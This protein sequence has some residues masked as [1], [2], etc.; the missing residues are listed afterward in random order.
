MNQLD[1][2]KALLAVA[3]IGIWGYGL[4]IDSRRLQGAG[5]A[6]VVVAFALRLLRRIRERR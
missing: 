3:G 2:L 6:L 5:L 1:V 4:R